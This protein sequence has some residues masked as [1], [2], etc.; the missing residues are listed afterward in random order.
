MSRK[1]PRLNALASRKQ[2]LIAESGLNRAHLMHE[3][4]TMAGEMHALARKAKT[5]SC[6]ASAAASLVAGLAFFRHKKS[7][8]AAESPSW[9]QS[10]L[11]VAGLFSTFWPAFRARPKT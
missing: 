1:N 2:L 8:S 11:K 10:T 5:A 4:Q 3:I 6:V 9:W 7:A